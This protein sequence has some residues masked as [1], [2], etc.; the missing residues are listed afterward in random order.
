L[1]LPFDISNNLIYLSGNGRNIGIFCDLRKLPY[2]ISQA[3]INFN[4]IITLGSNSNNIPFYCLGFTAFKFK[5]NILRNIL[6]PSMFFSNSINFMSELDYNNYFSDNNVIAYNN[7][8]FYY[9]LNTW[10]NYIQKDANSS[11]LNPYFNL[12]K[13]TL[14]ANRQLNGA[15]IA[16][17]G[18]LLDIDGEIRNQ[19]APDPGCDE[20]MV[21]FGVT[22]L[23]S[24]TLACAQEDSVPVTV[25]LSQFGDIPFI[26]LVIAY[27]V[28]GG[29]I[30]RDTIPG[31]I[32]NDLTYTFNQFQ[33]LSL[34]GAYNFKIWLENN[35]DDNINNDTLRI[36]RYSKS[37]PSVAIT[38]TTGCA[39]T[40]LNFSG[41][42][43]ITEGSIVNYLWEFGDGETDT[44]LFTNHTY[45]YS[46][47][48]PVKLYAFS[49]E[50]CYGS[51]VDT[52]VLAI[53]PDA[54][55]IV[56]DVCFRDS[57]QIYNTSKNIDSSSIFN[58]YVNG[59]LFSSLLEP[60]RFVLPAGSYLIKLII[61]NS[62][63]CLDSIVKSIKVRDLPIV[64]LPDYGPYCKNSLPV[65]ITGGQ[66]SGGLYVGSTLINR[67]FYPSQ[68][69]SGSYEIKYTYTDSL[70]C[71]NT[72]TTIIIVKGIDTTTIS[73]SSCL[74]YNWYGGKYTNSGVFYHVLENSFGCD[75]ILKLNLTINPVPTAPTLLTC[76][77]TANFNTTTC[78]WDVTG[79]QPTAPTVACYES[80][81][82]NSSTCA[83]DVTGTQP[84]QPT[85]ACYE[86]A[87][88]NTSTCVWDV[89]GTQP[90]Q[91][92]LACYETA[93]FNTLTCIWDV[94]GS[95]PTQPTLACYETASF[96]TSTCVWDVTGSQPSQ[97]TFACYETATFNT[98]T[99]V[100]DVTGTQPAQPT[101]AC[102]ES[103]KFNSSTCAWDIT[104][105]QPLMPTLACYETASFNTSTCVWDV[106]GLQPSMPTLACYETASFNT[107]TCVWDVTG[108][109]P[110]QPT[111]ACYE[112][113]NFNSTTCG[114]DVTGVQLAQPT[115]A[116]YQTATFNNSTCQWDVNG[117][118][119]TQPSLE[120]YQTALFNT[121][122]CQ[123]V[124]TG[125]PTPAIITNASA[126]S[127]YVWSANGQAYTQTGTY[128]YSAN[129]QNY[130]LNLTINQP[131]VA[132]TSINA[133]TAAGVTN[134]T[135]VGGQLGTNASWKWYSGSCGGTLVGTGQSINVSPTATTTY[136]VRAEGTCNTTSCVSNTVNVTSNC[137]P[138]NVISSTGSFTICKGS[139]IALTVQ[140]NAGTNGVWKWYKGSCSSS[141]CAYTGSSYT[142]APTVTTTYYVKASGGSCG[143]TSCYAVTVTVNRP[144]ST[145][146]VITG[147]ATG[148]CNMQNVAYSVTNVSGVTY[149]WSV[150]TGA[151]I[152]SGQGTNSILVNFSNILG[153]TNSCSSSP[154]ICVKGSNLCGTSSARCLRI[155]LTP[156][157]PKSI[158]GVSSLCANQVSTYSIAPIVG[159]TSYTW[160]KPSGWTIVSGQ[161]TTSIQVKA[162]TSTGS[163]G[164]KSN[165][166]CGSSSAQTKCISI[167]SCSR[168]EDNGDFTITVFPNPTSGILNI[169]SNELINRIELFDMLGK[170]VM[171]YGS[172]KQ[173]DISNLQSGLYLIRFT[174]ENGVEQRR[175]EVSR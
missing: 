10:R 148:L 167:T 150:P 112:S 171:T 25:C 162:G 81:N 20:F 111:L 4:T 34:N 12:P 95:Q 114:W 151:T 33:D 31:T 82:F 107:S 129:C 102:Y 11:N 28:N 32:T 70:G 118:Q 59:S 76:Y 149:N 143:T 141:I 50:G 65:Y 60:N 30:F 58:W 109:Q 17:N 64:T 46:G 47:I 91:P 122:S 16:A 84:S 144:P 18:I 78:T 127:S 163:I 101:L 174:S 126:C 130:T 48:Y 96:N 128:N 166:S 80:A 15:G 40:S 77:E 169:E 37:S 85:L 105:S 38:H 24:P 104:G 131:S 159:V 158:T 35:S 8:V 88:F 14:P 5:N 134:L 52:T 41:T 124:V 57:I 97:P 23:E 62:N 45:Q 146:S 119:P 74:E 26:N 123:W 86:T 120:C 113:A 173:I 71:S 147:P 7:G 69:S 92:T 155:S 27:Q 172:E 36:T 44:N 49:D 135:V 87:N 94:T 61:I 125:S 75:S 154:V 13:V 156:S 145:P 106:T 54:S 19:S 133:T 115:L 160:T 63:G 110:S 93:S 2:S 42:A 170:L 100:W 53:T 39:G 99:C 152:I 103:A 55:F 165:N 89:T 175:V 67:F 21:D 29:A 142:V 72:D 138:T 43:S 137:G 98:L 132:A 66:P 6:G 51:A 164:V 121:T 153:S 1:N 68:S 108:S 117:T 79:S 116:C 22:R 136:S 3:N 161:G 9:D 83:W 90:S 140:G 139:S 168:L 157:K 73:I 56:T